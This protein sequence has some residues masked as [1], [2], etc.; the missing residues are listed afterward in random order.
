MPEKP[1]R[2]SLLHSFRRVSSSGVPFQVCAKM[3]F[4]PSAT[5]SLPL[6]DCCALALVAGGAEDLEVLDRRG[7]A[8]REGDDVV[9]LDL[10][11]VKYPL[12]LVRDE[13]VSA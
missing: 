9:V 11:S 6:A 5:D 10:W 8:H 13:A 12:M 7:A 1:L 3:S 4:R 2:S